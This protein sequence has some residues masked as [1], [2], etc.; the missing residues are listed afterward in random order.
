MPT[1]HH[2]EHDQL[3]KKWHKDAKFQAAYDALAEEFDLFDQMLQARTEAGLTQEDVANRM[4]TQ[5]PA[6]ARLE[7]SGGK[8]RHSPSIETLRKYAHA[9]GCEL[10]IQLVRS[11]AELKK[12]VSTKQ[13]RK[14]HK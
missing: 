10:V 13:K 4:G 3:I 2:N 12:K 6:V 9:V 14:A 8:H 1:T 11:H 7:S 5:V